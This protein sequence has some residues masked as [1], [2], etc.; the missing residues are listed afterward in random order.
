MLADGS[1]HVKA[2]ETALFVLS[3]RNF[4]PFARLRHFQGLVWLLKDS[5][6]KKKNRLY[7]LT[8]CSNHVKALQKGTFYS[9]Q[10]CAIG[11]MCSRLFRMY[12]WRQLS[13][14]LETCP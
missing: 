11:V 7:M 14:G 12:K 1:N 3:G 4:G 5:F 2:D 13:F 9:V 6:R 8:D 10:Y